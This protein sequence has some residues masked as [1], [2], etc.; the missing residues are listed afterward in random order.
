M[1]CDPRVHPQE[2]RDRP[3]GMVNCPPK[4]SGIMKKLQDVGPAPP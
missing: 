1:S 4:G 2:A 3:Q